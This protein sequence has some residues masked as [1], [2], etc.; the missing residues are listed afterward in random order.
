M[1]V[2]RE[3]HTSEDVAFVIVPGLHETAQLVG[4]FEAVSRTDSRRLGIAGQALVKRENDSARVAERLG[5]VFRVSAPLLRDVM[6]AWNGLYQRAEGALLE[7]V[8]GLVDAPTGD[9]PG[10]Y[11]TIVRPFV[12]ELRLMMANHDNV[13][14]VTR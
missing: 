4:I 6:R 14:N 11:E 3:E 2:G 1:R 8:R 9:M 5:D 10:A 7:D 12:E 13:I